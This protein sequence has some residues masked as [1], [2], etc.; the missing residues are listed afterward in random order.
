MEILLIDSRHTVNPRI[1][2]Q[3]GSRY[4]DPTP[5]EE[6]VF[7]P[8]PMIHYGNA[9]PPALKTRDTPRYIH[10]VP[11]QTIRRQ[12][13]NIPLQKHSILSDL[14]KF[15]QRQKTTYKTKR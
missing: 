14:H 3:H 1:Q 8:R 5:G 9:I 4:S 7:L 12:E 2:A 6:P 11:D 10:T 15:I 13:A